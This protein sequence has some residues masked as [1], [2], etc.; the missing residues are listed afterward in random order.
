MA[1]Q[2]MVKSKKQLQLENDEL[3]NSLKEA[4]ET[5]NAIRSGDVDAIV[6]SGAEGEMIFSLVSAE[7]PYR[8]IVQEMN[9]G[10]VTLSAKGIIMYCNQRFSE[11][12]AVPSKKIVGSSFSRF[13]V[14]TD[15]TIFNNLFRKGLKSKTY[16]EIRC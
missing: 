7:T 1:T 16:V 3:L 8:I 6:V 9:E 4:E 10:V 5:L 14:N 13:V 15:Q 12:L 11:I 2:P